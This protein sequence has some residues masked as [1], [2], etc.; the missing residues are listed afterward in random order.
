MQILALSLRV[1]HA[2]DIGRIDALLARSYPRLLKADYPPSVM[3]TAVPRLARAKPSLVT[4]GRY[5]VAETAEGRVVGAGGWS[6]RSHAA[7]QG[8]MRHIATDPDV[9]RRGVARRLVEFILDEARAA[10]LARMDCLSTRTAVPFY[11]AMGFRIVGPVEI[12]L[13]A[14]IS[15][16]AVQMVR[17]I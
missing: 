1:A 15:F 10:G 16:P 5:Y 3:V 7:R 4:S 12:G 17:G 2:G 14:G 8:E 11:Q 6:I 9:V 13:E